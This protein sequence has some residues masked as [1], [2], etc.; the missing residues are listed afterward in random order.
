MNIIWPICKNTVCWFELHPSQ[1]KHKFLKIVN[2]I[3]ISLVNVPRALRKYSHQRNNNQ[4]LMNVAELFKIAQIR[5]IHLVQQHHNGAAR[6]K[7]RNNIC[8]YKDLQVLNLLN[9]LMGNAKWCIS[10]EFRS[11]F[12]RVW[13]VCVFLSRNNRTT[14]TWQEQKVGLVVGGK[15]FAKKWDRAALAVVRG[16]H[17]PHLK[18]PLRF[19]AWRGMKTK[20]DAHKLSSVLLLLCSRRRK[21]GF[22]QFSEKFEACEGGFQRKWSIFSKI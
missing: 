16:S 5:S 2:L 13:V 12:L 20:G 18:L 9:I 22:S 21:T 4:Y 8:Y 3:I 6:L 14:A 15:N 7:W 1:L 11:F 19:A 17:F 10:I